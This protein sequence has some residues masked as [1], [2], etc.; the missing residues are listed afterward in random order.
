MAVNRTSEGYAL[1]CGRQIEALWESLEAGTAGRA[2]S[3]EQDCPHCQTAL[4]GLTALRD[5]TRELAAEPVSVPPRLAGR[6]MAAVRADVRRTRM[7][8]LPMA[9]A[10]P[11]SDR[12]ACGAPP[13][14][15][16]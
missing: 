6:I 2:D 8:P 10:G 14:L 7:L 12:A 13:G 1:P 9:D 15:P 16:R 11:R 5:A 4:S 3:H